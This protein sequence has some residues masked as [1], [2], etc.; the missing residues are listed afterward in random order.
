MSE[1]LDYTQMDTDPRIVAV[2]SF[3]SAEKVSKYTPFSFSLEYLK[4]YNAARKYKLAVAFHSSKYGEQLIGAP[5]STLYI[6][7]VNIVGR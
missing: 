3:Q 2:G 7:E 4:E 1:T 6:D 5:G